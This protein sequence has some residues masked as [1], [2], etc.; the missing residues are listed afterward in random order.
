MGWLYIKLLS[1]RRPELT[2]ERSTAL[3]TLSTLGMVSKTGVHNHYRPD[4]TFV[5][6]CRIADRKQGRT[7]GRACQ[8]AARGANLERALKQHWNK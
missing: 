2:Q 6:S 7:K 5:L 1:R 8:A 4:V 3:S